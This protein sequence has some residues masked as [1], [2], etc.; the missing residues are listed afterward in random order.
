MALN[1][2]WLYAS[3]NTT[4]YRWKYSGERAPIADA[5]QIVISNM[6][7]GGKGGAPL[8]HTTRTIVFKTDGKDTPQYMYVSIGSGANV[9]AD[10]FRSRV[11]RVQLDSSTIV[12]VDGFDFST[13]EVWSD[14]LRNGVAMASD[15]QDRLWEV[16][17]GPDNLE[18]P[19]LGTD[20][21]QNNPAEELNLLDGP[22][23]KPFG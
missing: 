20:I 13:M 7:S 14:G 15:S 12:P 2:G 23:G 21:Y 11:R 9:D 5:P 6:S 19:D 10:S 18:R 1:Q 3:S 22:A 8:G 16:D 17:N 4:V